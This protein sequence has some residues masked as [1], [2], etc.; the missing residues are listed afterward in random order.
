MKAL[1]VAGGISQAALIKELKTRGIHTILADK[2]PKAVAVPFADEYYEVSTLDEEG[3]YQLA[4]KEKVDMVLT[5]CADQVLLI[6]AKVSERL[7]LPCYIDY[8]T[9]VNVS[10]KKHM[11]EIF[12]KNGVPTSKH[13]VMGEFDEKKVKGFEFPLIVKPVDAYSSR[14]G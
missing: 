12:V 7:G 9:A 4:L 6:T 3:I 11:K 13:V 14:G 8:E 10:D 1:V 2:N 5:A